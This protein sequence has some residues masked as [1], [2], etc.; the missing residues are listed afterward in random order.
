MVRSEPSFVYTAGFRHD[1]AG[2]DPHRFTGSAVTFL[3]MAR[4]DTN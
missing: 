4:F 1:D 2:V 3:A